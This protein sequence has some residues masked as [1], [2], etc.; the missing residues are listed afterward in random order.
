MVVSPVADVA[1][2]QSATETAPRCLIIGCGNPSRSDDGVGPWVA[3][4]LQ[5][6]IGSR[7][8]PDIR[9]LDAGT[10]GMEV[11]FAARGV[12]KLFIVDACRG[13]GVAGSVFRVPGSEL[14]E[15]S[16]HSYT[17]HDFRWNHAL[18]GGQQM[19]GDAFPTRV[20]VFLVEAASLDFGL[21][22][23]TVVQAGA[24]QVLEALERE[25]RALKPQTVLTKA[26]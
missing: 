15:A 3:R 23:S 24:E 8:G 10:S 26:N 11:M 4:E 16:D 17:M 12:E 13:G 19:Y 5:R 7:L 6:R 1:A 21:Q 20:E 9:I 2:S 25:I 18:Y 22:L 14:T